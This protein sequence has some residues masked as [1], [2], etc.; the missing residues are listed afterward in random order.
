[1]NCPRCHSL[2]TIKHG[3]ILA[4]RGRVQRFECKECG[5]KFHPPLADQPLNRIQGYLDIEASQLNASFGHMLTWALKLRGGEIL[6]DFIKIRSLTEE[7]RIVKSLIRAMGKV[8][9]VVTYYGTRFDLPFI[10][11]RALYHGLIF[12]EYMAASHLDLYYVARSRLRMHSNRL[13]TVADF[14]GAKGKTNLKPEVWVA[15]SF[16]DKK[17]IRYILNHNIADVTILEKVHEKLEPF[18]RGVQRSI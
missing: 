2:N 12:P 6:S 8:D 11:T 3:S 16:G 18:M 17:A 1:M 9:E 4:A 10:R 14:L 5:K 7:K 15:A 13:G